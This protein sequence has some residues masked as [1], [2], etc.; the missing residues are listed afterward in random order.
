MELLLF[1]IGLIGGALAETPARARGRHELV[2]QDTTPFQLVDGQ[3]KPDTAFE[4]FRSIH[5]PRTRV[6]FGRVSGELVGKQT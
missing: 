4:L 1:A 3:E 5:R 6:S 2:Q